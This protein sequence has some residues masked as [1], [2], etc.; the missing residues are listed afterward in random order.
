MH[1]RL[2]KMT[3]NPIIISGTVIPFVDKVR[4]LGVV[5]TRDLTWN[6]HIANISSKIHGV[7]YRL[8]FSQDSLS[9]PIRRLLINSL[10][11]PH[12]DYCCLVFNDSPGYLE[13]KLRRLLNACIKFVYR[14]KRETPLEP[15]RRQAGW[16][17][18]IARRKYFLGCTMYR[19]LQTDTPS[20]LR[21]SFIEIRE[22]MLRRSPRDLSPRFI[23]PAKI[24]SNIYKNSFFIS[25]IELWS[26]LPD[27]I[28]NAPSYGIFK[29]MLH[30]YILEENNKNPNLFLPDNNLKR[31]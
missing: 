13:L 31:K 20:Y 18:P 3:L 11:L 12:F 19:I 28:V 30:D 25:A 10:I 6:S 29:V 24:A 7:L 4:N 26:L 16:F 23:L 2:D 8:R 5:M 15:Y 27:E 17:T 1:L 14:V 9:T 21:S 22:N